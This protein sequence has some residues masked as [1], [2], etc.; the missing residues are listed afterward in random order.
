MPDFL[1]ATIAD[2]SCTCFSNGTLHML[3]PVSRRFV[4]SCKILS[5][6][7][8]C[9]MPARIPN[10]LADSDGEANMSRQAVATRSQPR[11][12]SSDAVS[13]ALGEKMLQVIYLTPLRFIDQGV[14]RAQKCSC[15]I[16][17]SLRCHCS[18]MIY[19]CAGLDVAG[20]HLPKV[21]ALLH[22]PLIR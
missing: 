15:W 10:G 1:Q 20:R 11:G 6:N 13:Q 17:S 2:S 21:N 12:P 14:P 18:C 8:H 19:P 5:T 7:A 16:Y 3:L 9:S 22:L 4:C